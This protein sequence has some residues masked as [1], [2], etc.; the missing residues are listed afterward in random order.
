VKYEALYAD[1][2]A[3][4]G[5]KKP[6]QGGGFLA[7]HLA[8][9]DAEVPARGR[10]G[11]PSPPRAAA[12]ATSTAGTCR[13]YLKLVKDIPAAEACRALADEIG[14]IDTPKK[15]YKILKEAIGDEVQEVFVVLTLDVHNG[16]LG[17]AQTGA[18]NIDSTPAPIIPT[19]RVAVMEGATSIVIAHVH[20]A[21]GETGPS[22]ADEEVTKVF[23]T[24]CEQVDLLLLDHVIVSSGGYFSFLEDGK[25]GDL[26]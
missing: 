3:S 8:G 6:P 24:A 1:R 18:G 25:L 7:R 11:R 10:R 13:P 26:K 16:L 19:L 14:P 2:A 21:G 12:S 5:C 20:P 4:C 9:L 22:E 17:I 15:A 23:E